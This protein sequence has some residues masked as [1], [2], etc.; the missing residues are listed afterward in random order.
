MHTS[1]VSRRGIERVYLFG[2]L[3]ILSL[4]GLRL[5]SKPTRTIEWPLNPHGEEARMR[6]LEP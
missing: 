4:C 2:C 5:T 1:G 6:R 3:K